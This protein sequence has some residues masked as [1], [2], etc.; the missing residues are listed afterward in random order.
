[1]SNFSSGT[2]A[3]ATIAT[4]ANTALTAGT[5]YFA[6]NAATAV[7]A[8]TAGTS[9]GV[10]GSAITKSQ[11]SDFTSGTV[12]S[13]T[14]AGTASYSTT[15]G[16]ALNAGTAISLSGSITKSQVSDFTSGTVTT[17]SGSITKS[18][19]SDFTSGTVASATSATSAGTASTAGTAF[20]S[21]TSGTSLTIS[22]SITNSQVSDFAS[23]TVANISGTV[24]QAQVSGLA[25]TLSGKANLGSAN[26]FTTGG[27]TITNDATGTVPLR[28][29]AITGQTANLLDIKDGSATSQVIINSAGGIATNQR[30]TTGQ[31]TTSTAGHLAVILGVD[32]VGL[33]VR[34]VASQS[35]NL[36]EWQNSGGTVFA[37]VTSSGA[38]STTQGVLTPNLQSTTGLTTIALIGNRNAQFGSATGS[39]GGGTAVIG[40]ANAS[41]VPTSN[42]VGGGILYVEAGAL[43]YRGSSGTITT[44]GAA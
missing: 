40:I 42:P 19:V 23:G 37:S 20:Y 44:L 1:V 5:A 30:F 38:L 11:I 34:G 12:A 4:S 26:A 6:S 17:I 36:T 2:V 35:F 29:L 41:A 27:H 39:V 8:T 9:I 33:A 21:T 10:S 32:R 14:I 16:S 15:S 28:I 7:Y 3:S 18:Q 25:S 24:T 31:I 22:G 13:A 43:K